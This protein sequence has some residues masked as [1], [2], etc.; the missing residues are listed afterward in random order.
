MFMQAR[1]K[2]LH[3]DI[4]CVSK[5]LEKSKS[6]PAE[7]RLNK[8]Q[9]I[10]ETEYRTPYQAPDIHSGTSTPSGDLDLPPTQTYILGADLHPGR[11]TS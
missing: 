10:C 7:E 9:H 6:P 1:S 5:Y 2:K 3:P 4:I 8:L 11:R